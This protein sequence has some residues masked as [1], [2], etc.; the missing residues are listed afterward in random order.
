MNAR[1]RQWR[2][3]PLSDKARGWLLLGMLAINLAGIV[4]IA[5]YPHDPQ[6]AAL[7]VSLLSAMLAVLP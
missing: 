3:R 7:G 1:R 4:A 6:R 5:L 2:L